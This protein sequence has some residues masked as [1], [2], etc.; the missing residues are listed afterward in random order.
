[1]SISAALLPQ[2]WRGHKINVIDTPG[3]AD[4]VGEVVGA[5]AVADAVVL[6]VD[7]QGGVEAQ[8]EQY[9]K[10]ARRRGLP[11]L[12]FV[13]KL[14]KENADFDRMVEALTR[15]LDCRPVPIVI[16]RGAGDKLS[17]VVD[18]LQ[19]KAYGAPAGARPPEAEDAPGDFADLIALAREQIMEAAAEAEDALTEKYLEQGD[20]TAEEVDRGLRGATLAGK[21]APIICGSATKVIG[22][23]SLLDA[24]VACLPSPLDCG[25]VEVTDARSHESAKRP[26]AEDQPTAALIFKTKADPFAGKVSFFRTY[27]G[28]VHSDHT[29]FNPNRDRKERVGQCYIPHGKRQDAVADVPAG[30]FAAV[31]KLHDSVTGDTLCDE[32]HVVTLPWVDMPEPAISFAITPKSRGDEDKMSAALHRLAEEDLTLKTHIDPDTRETII[33]GMGDL[34][35]E[36]A[37]NRLKVKFGVEVTMG[38]P[39]VAYRE[40]IR[41]GAQAQGK[42]KRQ[43]GGRGQYGDVWIELEPLPRGSGVV[44]EDRIVGGVVPRNYIPS[45]E[46]GM[47]EAAEKGFLAGFPVVDLKVSLY[48]G[49]YHNVDSSDMAFKIAGSMGFRNAMERAQPILL[50]PVMEL[51]VSVPE[52]NTGDVMG[53][54]NGKRGRILGMEPAGETQ[55]VRAHVPLSEI[56]AFANELRS[57][58]GGRGTYAMKFSHHEEVPAHI[59]TA[60]IAAS[61]TEEEE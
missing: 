32:Q 51:E 45:V 29:L 40:T 17:G 56:F 21:M 34:H 15:R 22:I 42:F 28:A 35:L 50:E 33:S 1:V 4:F 60:I 44:F 54:L 23:H 41:S 26:P 46:K 27:T 43:T 39:K 61:K 11:G 7:G 18:V 48:D 47:R 31:A 16:P 5:I 9:W 12:V 6:V 24:I 13:N 3:Y 38:T 55:M 20:L 25:E 37:V 36:V 30:D 10:L 49:S 19:G 14:D 58:T 2:T 53:M 8:A 59:A 57:M 52:A